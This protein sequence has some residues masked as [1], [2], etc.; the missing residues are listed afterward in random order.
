MIGVGTQDT[1]GLAEVFVT[2]AGLDD[3]PA[4]FVW[5]QTFET[6]QSFGVNVNSSMVLVSSD[7][8]QVSDT[9]FGFSQAQQ[10]QILDTAASLS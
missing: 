5:D 10:Q 6:W 8:T 4:T 7:T 3:T 9:F 2:E 1:L